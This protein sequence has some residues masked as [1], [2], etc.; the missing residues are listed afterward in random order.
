[1]EDIPTDR[2]QALDLLNRALQ[3][4]HARMYALKLGFSVSLPMPSGAIL[5]WEKIDGA[6]G[7]YVHDA[8]AWKRILEAKVHHRIEA[9]ARLDMLLQQAHEMGLTKLEEIRDAT[10]AAERF[11]NAATEA[12]G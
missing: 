4:A 2:A 11:A 5:G 7:Y 8:G 1:M 10:R 6:W 3:L 9:A 12:A